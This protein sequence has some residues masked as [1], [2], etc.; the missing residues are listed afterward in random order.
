MLPT[1]TTISV[2]IRE[3]NQGVIHVSGTCV[4]LVTILERYKVGD[5][6]QQIHEGFETVPLSDI[7]TIIAYYL[8]NRE[9]VDRYIEGVR[10][11][12]DQL[13]QQIEGAYTP[14]QRVRIKR[15]RQLAE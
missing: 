6:P 4:T 12:G 7:H 13:R 2:P 9:A 14:E 3:D 5:T 15:L 10:A 11:K 1:P 8:A